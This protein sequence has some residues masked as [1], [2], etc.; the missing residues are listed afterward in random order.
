MTTQEMTTNNNSFLAEWID[1]SEGVLYSVSTSAPMSSIVGVLHESMLWLG[2]PS[3]HLPTSITLCRSVLAMVMALAIYHLLLHRGHSKKRKKLA[4]EL[5]LAQ[6]QLRYLQDKLDASDDDDSSTRDN[7]KAVRIFIDGAFDMMHYGHMN[8]FRLAR[9]LG[10]H[11]IVGINSDESITECKGSSPLMNDQERLTMVQACKFVDEVIPGAP[12]I[13]NREY[14]DYVF[15]KYK[16]D[17]VIHGDDPCLVNGKDVYAAAKAMGKFRSIPRTEGVS[18]TDI[19][20]R[21][22]VMTKEHHYREQQQTTA[23]ARNRDG[24]SSSSSSPTTAVVRSKFLTTS[25]M[26]RLFS[27]G[28]KAPPLNAKVIY[29]D[30]AW[31]MFHCGHVAALKAAKERGDYLIVG[32]HGDAVV[33]QH[34]GHNLPLMNLHERV[35]SVLGCRFA[36]DVLIDAP[37]VITSDMIASL[38]ISEVIHGTQSDEIFVSS[39]SSSNGSKKTSL[40]AAAQNGEEDRYK[41]V[42]EA[43]LL[44]IMTSPSDFN[45]GH[46]FQR[47]QKHQEMFQAKFERKMRAENDY[48]K[49]RYSGGING[50]GESNGN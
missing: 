34:R 4:A 23:S 16:I 27:A 32:I 36:D 21:M 2:V 19:V 24:G 31:D 47:I 49:Q 45:L 20:G 12:Y 48:Y 14:L 38:H 18:T 1:A 39:S 10:T 50:G 7:N 42:R 15:D 30:G 28:I 33:N 6:A 40:K 41:F 11:L 3:E 22:L 17:Y 5:E 25:H 9:S 13:M 37:Y 43:G 46:V 44:R 35:L 29:M 26:L 8:A